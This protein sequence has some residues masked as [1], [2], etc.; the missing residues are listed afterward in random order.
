MRGGL[1]TASCRA[2]LGLLVGSTSVSRLPATPGDVVLE[3]HRGVE[4]PVDDE[5]AMLA[6]EGACRQGQFGFHRLAGR[7][8]FGGG[9]PAVGDDELAAVPGRLVVELASD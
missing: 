5:T 6:G 9:E 2:R 7:T 1:F 8:R 4:V 3:V